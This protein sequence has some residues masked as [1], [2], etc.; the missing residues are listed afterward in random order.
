MKIYFYRMQI[1]FY[2]MKVIFIEFCYISATINIWS[3]IDEA[4]YKDPAPKTMKEL[5]S[6]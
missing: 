5:K 2:Q 6:D 3:I 4:T 1:Y